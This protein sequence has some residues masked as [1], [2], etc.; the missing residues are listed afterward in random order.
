MTMTAFQRLRTRIG[1]A[2]PE[3]RG[4]G[5]WL[6]RI[7]RRLTPQIPRPRFPEIIH[8][9][10]ASQPQVFFIQVG[11]NDASYGDPLRGH[12]LRRRWHGIMVEPVP[13]VFQRLQARFGG[14]AELKLENVAIGPRSGVLP[15]YCLK[16]SDE[17]NLPPWYDQ[18]G[19]FSMNNILKHAVYLPDIA[20]RIQ[21]I[22]VPTLTM[23]ELCE[24]HDVHRLDILHI[25]AEG[26]DWEI[27]KAIDFARIRPGILLFEHKH[28]STD[29]DR[30]SR[31]HLQSLGY[32]LFRDKVDTFCMHAEVLTAGT[33]ALRAAWARVSGEAA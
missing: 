10:A 20:Q 30:A 9:F 2:L 26:Y 12:I 14:H 21:K 24:K 27:I 31:E 5:Y 1:A 8:A 15:F 11:S 32:R 17:P 33:V 23:A 3:E 19:S 29:D 22:A 7:Y 28:L 16:Q 6:R 18:L 13:Y 4:L 25:D